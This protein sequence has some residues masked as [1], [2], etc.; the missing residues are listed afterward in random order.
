MI[1]F[2]FSGREREQYDE[3]NRLA[4]IIGPALHEHIPGLMITAEGIWILID[5]DVDEDG[6]TFFDPANDATHALE[7]YK[8]LCGHQSGYATTANML[9]RPV[10]VSFDYSDHQYHVVLHTFVRGCKDSHGEGPVFS[11]ALGR[12][13]A[14][15][16]ATNYLL[17]DNPPTVW[18]PKTWDD[19][20]DKSL[21]F[22]ERLF[23][24]LIV[25]RKREKGDDV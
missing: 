16:V 12:A 14:D 9:D 5:P 22:I 13:V 24:S 2:E 4:K 8:A 25:I 23:D 3:M 10:A 20:R 18:E 1:T 6:G 11:T 17:P 7:A 15:Y 19:D 21:G